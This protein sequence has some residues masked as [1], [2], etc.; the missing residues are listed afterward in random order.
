MVL[1]VREAVRRHHSDILSH[2]RG[3]GMEC[4]FSTCNFICGSALT[5]C[6]I[7]IAAPV[8][9]NVSGSETRIF[10]NISMNV[11]QTKSSPFLFLFLEMNSQLKNVSF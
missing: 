4:P 10:E 2:Q 8:S 3:P 1:V 6:A 11:P 9:G 7:L 5:Q